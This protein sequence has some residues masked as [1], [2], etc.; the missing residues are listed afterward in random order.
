MMSFSGITI[1]VV[2][3]KIVWLSV[4]FCPMEAFFVI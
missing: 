1:P 3:I 4:A 2:F